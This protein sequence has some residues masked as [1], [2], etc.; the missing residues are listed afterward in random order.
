MK[1]DFRRGLNFLAATFA[2]RRDQDKEATHH[3]QHNTNFTFK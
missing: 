3:V 1:S 2:D